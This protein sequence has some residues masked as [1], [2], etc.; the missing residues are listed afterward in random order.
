MAV[1][2]QELLTLFFGFSTMLFHSYD[3]MRVH[4]KGVKNFERTVLET[5]V[6]QNLIT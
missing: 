4:Q 2:K 5:Y 3:L 1:G 6:I